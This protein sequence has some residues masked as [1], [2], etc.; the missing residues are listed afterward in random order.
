MI[1]VHRARRA[2]LHVNK[3][4]AM[5]RVMLGIVSAVMLSGL[6]AGCKDQT[7]TEEPVGM[8]PA[9]APPEVIPEFPEDQVP[10]AEPQPA[11]QTVSASGAA[12]APPVDT[13]ATSAQRSPS[14]TP[15]PLPKESYTPVPRKAP[16]TYVVR[17][18]DTL[19]KISK[20]FYNSTQKW[21]TIYE[22]NRSALK[23]GPNV[24]KVGMKL[25]IP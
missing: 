10:K 23:D 16:R 20:Q 4:A 8:G 22:A 17:Q 6:L 18:G 14:A 15:A 1:F 12:N 24:L 13:S 19:Q 3:E 9:Q 5:K 21:R 25:Q 7:L 11:G 2:G